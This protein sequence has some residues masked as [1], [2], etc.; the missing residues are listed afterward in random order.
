VGL[1]GQADKVFALASLCLSV[2]T[3]AIILPDLLGLLS[4]VDSSGPKVGLGGSQGQLGKDV[5][6]QACW[7]EGEGHPA[8]SSTVVAFRGL[9]Q[10][11]GA[12]HLSLSTSHHG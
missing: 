4:K 7:A 10:R 3:K 1:R 2:V 12:G 8:W 6:Q 5:C 11:Q 9:P